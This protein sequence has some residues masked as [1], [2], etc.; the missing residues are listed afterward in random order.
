M[1]NVLVTG[2]AGFIGSHIVEELIFQGINVTIF[3][4]LSTGFI[5]NIQQFLD[6]KNVKFVKGDILDYD[7]LEEVLKDIDTVFHLAAKISVAESMTNEV[8]YVKVNTIGTLNVL[9]AGVKNNLKNIVLSSSAAIY[10]DNPIIPKVETML[11]EP[12]SPYAITKLDGE[13]YFKMF[14]EEYGINAVALRYFNVFGARQNPESQYAAA[15]PIFINK[16]LKN[17]DIVIFGD[18]EQTRDFIYVK[19]IVKANIFAAKFGGDIFNVST[20]KSIT[21]NQLAEKIIRLTGSKSKIVHT[22]PRPGD[23]KHS[24]GDNTKIINEL[25]FDKFCDF[26]EALII[27]INYFKDLFDT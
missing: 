5:R 22:D 21:I 27:T 14:R 7:L 16:A 17:E 20:G 1:Q 8:E 11:P 2:G 10:G 4:N 3:D 13:Y 19:D 18:G 26:D 12:K 23:V 9:K 24:R 15:I 6:K 25:S